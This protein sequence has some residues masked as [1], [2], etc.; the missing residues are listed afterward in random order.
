MNDAHHA[1]TVALRKIGNRHGFQFYRWEC[2]EEDML[3]TGCVCNSVYARG[4]RKGRPKYDGTPRQA[5]VT[6]AELKVERARYETEEGKCSDCLGTA[7][8][9]ASAGKDG[10]TYRPCSRCHGTGKPVSVGAVDPA[11]EK[12]TT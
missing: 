10:T 11:G 1:E 5:V 8:T 4:P 2:I 9:L 12:V 7:R 3:L 6:D